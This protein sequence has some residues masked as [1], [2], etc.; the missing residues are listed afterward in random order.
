MAE[1]EN[2]KQKIKDIIENDIEHKWRTFSLADVVEEAK[3][4]GI[5]EHEVEEIMHELIEDNYI[6]E[7]RGAHELYERTVWKD[8]NPANEEGPDFS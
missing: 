5:S 8:Y 4:Q 3:I 2:L 7:V 6:H 1:H